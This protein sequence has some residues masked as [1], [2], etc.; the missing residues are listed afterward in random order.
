ME[1]AWAGKIGTIELWVENIQERVEDMR[2]PW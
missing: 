2:E 1:S